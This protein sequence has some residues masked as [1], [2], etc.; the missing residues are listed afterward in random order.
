M[1]NLLLLMTLLMMLTSQVIA[2]RLA[3]AIPMPQQTTDMVQMHKTDTA[4]DCCKE[5]MGCKCGS[6]CTCAHLGDCSNYYNNL[7]P[8]TSL[9]EPFKIQSTITKNISYSTWNINST[10]IGVETPPPDIQ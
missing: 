4:T 9:I 2:P 10:T 7:I 8:I 6:S 5:E 3:L 1:R